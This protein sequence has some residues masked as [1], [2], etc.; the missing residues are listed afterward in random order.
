MYKKNILLACVLALLL[1]LSACSHRTDNPTTEAEKQET[2]TESW[3]PEA[4]AGTTVTFY[5]WGGSQQTNSWIDGQL[6]DL[7]KEKYDITIERVGMNIDEVLNLMLGEKQAGIKDNGSVDVVWIN[8]ENFYTARENDLLYGPFTDQLPNF[9]A[10]VDATDPEVQTDF[11]HPIDGYEAPYGKA[12]FVFIYDSHHITDVPRNSEELLSW[13]KEN[14]G[15][16]TYAAMPDFTGSAFVRNIISD[17][18][19]YETFAEMAPDKETVHEAIQPA[20]DYL[21]ELAP[22]L[23]NEGRSYPADTPQLANMY[24]DGEI[25]MHMSYNPNEASGKME[26][27][28]FPAST[29]TFLFD[30]GTIG[31]THFVAIG[32][33]SGNIPGA[34]ALI[35]TI[36]SP[37]AQAGKYDPAVWGDMPVLTYEMLSEEQQRLFDDVPQGPATPELKELQEKRL[38]EMPA[39]LV[40]II[41]ELWYENV[42]S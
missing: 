1:L 34:L 2:Q 12:Q 9:S 37:E 21:N 29:R 39:H 38:P 19:G 6:T 20:L 15:R 32:K 8:G 33:N 24:A 28:E 35:D 4:A 14:P 3:N 27:G 36:L 17:L 41:E 22:Y 23:W 42:A 7:A 26:T 40:P 5:G 10:Y 18:I 31:N 16:F 30:K 25:W 13:A 11:G